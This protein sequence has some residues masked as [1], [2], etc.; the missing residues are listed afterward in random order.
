[1]NEVAT[2]EII[3]STTDRIVV[4]AGGGGVVAVKLCQTSSCGL[5]SR[6]ALSCSVV[7]WNTITQLGRQSWFS[8]DKLAEG[9]HGERHGPRSEKCVF[10]T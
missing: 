7:P 10:K 1:M 6:T 3:I 4:V 9:R 2:R 8:S 5:I